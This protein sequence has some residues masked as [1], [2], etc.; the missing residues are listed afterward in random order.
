MTEDTYVCED[1]GWNCLVA[2]V[3][4]YLLVYFFLSNDGDIMEKRGVQCGGPSVPD[5]NF[6][7]ENEY[8]LHN[9]SAPEGYVIFEFHL[10]NRVTGAR[11]P[12]MVVHRQ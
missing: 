6:V 10:E 9:P 7:P 12:G 3:S 11:G 1:R 5:V 8:K 2:L 4:G